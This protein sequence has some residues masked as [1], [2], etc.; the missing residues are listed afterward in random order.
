MVDPNYI[1]GAVWVLCGLLILYLGTYKIGLQGRADLHANY[2]D[3]VDPAFVSRWVGGTTFLMGA[4]VVGYGIREMLYG[5]HPYALAMLIVT[6]LI[7][8]Y[9]TKLFARGVGYRDTHS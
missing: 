1:S 4:L 6:L 5:F 2:D 7:L 3:D 9:I 8:S